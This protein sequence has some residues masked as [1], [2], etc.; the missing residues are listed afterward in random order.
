MGVRDSVGR[1]CD[2]LSVREIRS[3]KMFESNDYELSLD[4]RL[5]LIDA[6]KAWAF[7]CWKRGRRTQYDRNSEIAKVVYGS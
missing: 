4:E 5:S 3:Y 2:L 7:L 6:L 1:L